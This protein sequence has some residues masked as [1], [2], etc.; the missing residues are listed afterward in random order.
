MIDICRAGG[1]HCDQ[2]HG[3]VPGQLLCG[4]LRVPLLDPLPGHGL[5]LPPPGLRRGL[6]HPLRQLH[7]RAHTAACQ[8]VNITAQPPCF[9]LL[10]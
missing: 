3:A 6:P 2:Q 9:T 10:I 8:H 5:L 7:Q 4:Q 1:V